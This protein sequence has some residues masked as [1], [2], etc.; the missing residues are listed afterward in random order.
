MAAAQEAENHRNEGGLTWYFLWGI[1]T[2]IPTWIHSQNA[3]A[4]SLKIS[5]L[6]TSLKWSWRPSQSARGTPL[7][8]WWK[9]NSQKSISQWRESHRRTNGGLQNPFQSPKLFGELALLAF[10]HLN[11]LEISTSELASPYFQDWLIIN[12]VEYFQIN[13]TKESFTFRFF[14]P[15]GIIVPSA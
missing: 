8:I 6:Q 1:Y 2:S 10:L 3:E 11:L 5:S 13:S 9:V 15:I 7:W 4:P 14:L 12:T